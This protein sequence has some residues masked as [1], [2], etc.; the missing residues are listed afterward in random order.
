MAKDKSF[1]ANTTGIWRAV[2]YYYGND[3]DIALYGGL[4]Q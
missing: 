2:L 3:A 1:L 4:L